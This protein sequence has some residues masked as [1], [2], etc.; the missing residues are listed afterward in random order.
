M[1]D[2]VLLYLAKC[3]DDAYMMDHLSRYSCMWPG[4]TFLGG[5]IQECMAL[6]YAWDENAATRMGSPEEIWMCGIL[7]EEFE[8]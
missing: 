6:Q 1:V 7:V 5:S 4:R 8:N 2:S 3:G